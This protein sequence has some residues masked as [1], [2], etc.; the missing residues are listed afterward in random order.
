MV[1]L[2]RNWFR[3]LTHGA[4]LAPLGR[5]LLDLALGRYFVDA[6]RQ[7]TTRT[8]R[9][10]LALMLATLASSPVFTVTGLRQ[11]RQVRRALGLYTFLYVTLHFLTFAGWDYGFDFGLLGPAIL[12][13]R[14]VLAGVVTFVIMLA[15]AITST[16]GW[17]ARMGK[18]WQRLHRLFY[19]AAILDILH[20]LL[21]VKDTTRPLRYGGLVGLL[22]FARIPP[23]TRALGKV[24]RLVA[25]RGAGGPN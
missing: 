9:V 7:I 25:P 8:G 21:L 23:V 19:V 2:K 22:L 11:A 12:S 1:W 18:N 5:M 14:F 16:R 6:A 13:Q 3:V 10:A 20:F 24:R 15:L 17:Q 4:A